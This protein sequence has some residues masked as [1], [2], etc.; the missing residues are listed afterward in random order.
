MCILLEGL[1]APAALSAQQCVKIH[2]EVL[3]C[4]LRTGIELYRDTG[5][6]LQDLSLT[7]VSYAESV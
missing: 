1:D 6:I 4:I 5:S 7:T 3:I 2:E